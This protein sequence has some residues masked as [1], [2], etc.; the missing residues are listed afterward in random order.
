L[1]A[2]AGDPDLQIS[3]FLLPGHVSAIL[4]EQAYQFLKIPAVI[5]GFEPLDIL[6]GIFEMIQMLVQK[7]SYILNAYQRVVKPDGN[8]LARKMM[9]DV[10]ETVDADWR[11][12]GNIPKSG[13]KIWPQFKLWDAQ[14]KFNLRTEMDAM[15]RGC[16]CG[17]VLKG[18]IK[19]KQCGLFAKTC[20][21]E[22][23][24]GPCMVSSEGS[25]AAYYRYER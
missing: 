14:E 22:T 5:T 9:N 6:L 8:P 7:K 10:F 23:P 13:L 4:G 15:P 18:K 21:P 3:G 25:C 1:A 16:Q 24:V 12:I 11:G 17:E 2:L 20:T 19:P